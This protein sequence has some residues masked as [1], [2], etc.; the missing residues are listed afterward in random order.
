VE[1]LWRSLK[2]EEVYLHAYEGVRETRHGIARYF[3]YYNDRRGHA[4]LGGATPTAFY[5]AA[6]RRCAA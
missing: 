5:D 6:L 2:Y 4:S 1:R 3:T